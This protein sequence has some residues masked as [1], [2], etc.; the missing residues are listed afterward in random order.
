MSVGDTDQRGRLSVGGGIHDAW[1][2]PPW[3]SPY[4]IVRSDLART[5]ELARPYVHGRVL[6]LACGSKPYA[7]LLRDRAQSHWGVDLSKWDGQVDVVGDIGRLPFATGSID[8]IVC[9]E[10][11][12]HVPRPDE[13]VGEMSRILAPGGSIILTTPMTWGLHATPHDYWRFTAYGLRELTARNGLAIVAVWQRGGGSKVV[14]QMVA[15]WLAARSEQAETHARARLVRTVGSLLR[16]IALFD[17]GL[18]GRSVE[19]SRQGLAG[20]VERAVPRSPVIAPVIGAINRIATALD[21]SA[22]WD[23]ET[24]GFTVVLAARNQDEGTD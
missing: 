23:D 17:A 24:L 6:D 11:L 5:I 18:R 12:E 20:I 19:R 3:S 13:V 9:T 22:R 16:P 21:R 1:L 14:G 2:R 7:A 4:R 8:T 10:G 15:R